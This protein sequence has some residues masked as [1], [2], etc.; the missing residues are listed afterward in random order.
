MQNNSDP[1]YAEL[2]T[3]LTQLVH[4][5]SVIQGAKLRCLTVLIGNEV[6]SH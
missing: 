6:S 5:F 4:K 1:K 2:G 3:A